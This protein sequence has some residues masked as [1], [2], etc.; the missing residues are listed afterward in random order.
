MVSFWNQCGFGSL[1]SLSH[2]I[3]E[4]QERIGSDGSQEEEGK[5][6]EQ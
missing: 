1:G 5:N 2:L 3:P 4:A 6:R